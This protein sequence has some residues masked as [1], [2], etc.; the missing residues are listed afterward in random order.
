MRWIRM[1]YNWRVRR[2]MRVLGELGEN[3]ESEVGCRLHG[4]WN[5]FMRKY[6]YYR[7]KLKEKERER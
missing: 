6:W 3:P 2:V 7:G 4:K 5:R 1:Y